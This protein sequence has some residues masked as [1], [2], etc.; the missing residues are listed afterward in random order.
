MNLNT[1]LSEISGVGPRTS[2]LL[3]DARLITVGDLIDFLPRKYEDFSEITAIKDLRPGKVTVRARADRVGTRRFRNLSMTEAVL[4]DEN[5]DTTRAVW[6]NQTYRTKQLEKGEFLFS[7]NLELKRGKWQLTNPAVEQVKEMNI[8]T[9]R[10]LPIYAARKGLKAA[11]TRKIL[12]ELK[13][14][15]SVLPDF[16]PE[17]IL[18]KEQLLP[19]SNALMRIHFPES[20]EEYTKARERLAFD[21]LFELLLA[22]KLNK[23]ENSKLHGFLMKFESKW[24]REFIE[25]L[26][27][28]PTNA[29]KRAIWEIV[30][31]MEKTTPMTRLLQ[32]D[33]GSGK[34]IVAA[35][36]AFV[37]A[38][39][40]FQSA[41]MTPTAILATQH[42]LGLRAILEP[43]GLKIALLTGGNSKEK[44]EIL[45][46]MRDGNIDILIGTHA[47]FQEAVE[48]KKLGFVVIDEQHRFGVGQRN[49]LL[50]KVKNA[51][52]LPHLLSMTATPIPRSLQLTVFGDLDVSVLDELP[53]NRTPIKTKIWRNGTRDKLHEFIKKELKNGRQTYFVARLIEDSKTDKD[54]KSAQKLFKEITEKYRDYKVGILHGKMP[55]AAKDEVMEKFKN[56]EL[57]I[58]VSTTVI[59]V[60]VDVPNATIM[61]IENGDRF[62]LA[63]LHQ[64]RGRVGRGDHQSYCFVMPTDIEKITKRLTYIE[65]STDGFFLAEK[66]LELRGPGEVY[67]TAQHG[68]LN[69]QIA[70]LAD[71]KLIHRVGQSVEWFIKNKN[72]DNYPT[73]KNRIHREQQITTLN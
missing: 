57:D 16:M 47:L 9:G 11:T 58:L 68:E 51:E 1:K 44:Q 33:V 13:P 54:Q 30:Q 42:Y 52:Y 46:Q 8:N 32:G 45:A 49:K 40:G 38:K 71:T 64:L 53:N 10:V 35:A 48:F 22:A 3:K 31:D 65:Q 36:S 23:Q 27:F 6:W 19:L 59:E 55:V 50:Q 15:I 66:D 12:S 39:N 17:E 70:N 41:I 18:S 37:A 69:L 29:Q 63:Q 4:K 72:L 21:E 7:G 20:L 60:G 24:M 73:L 61:V 26:P 5:G 25:K 56:H 62:G 28:T 67:G 14:L 2:T 34:T 43:L